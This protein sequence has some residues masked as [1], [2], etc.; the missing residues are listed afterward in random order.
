MSA[1]TETALP[2]DLSAT[3]TK[4]IRGGGLKIASKKSSNG[5]T[6]EKPHFMS[7]IVEL[8]SDDPCFI[9]MHAH[10]NK[11]KEWFLDPQLQ[12]GKL[13]NERRPYQTNRGKVTG[14]EKNFLIKY[15]TLPMEIRSAKEAV[16]W[17]AQ[18]K[19]VPLGPYETFLLGMYEPHNPV[20]DFEENERGVFLRSFT[21]NRKEHHLAIE[22]MDN[23]PF[24]YAEG[25]A[26]I[27]KKEVR[28]RAFCRLR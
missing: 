14:G 3:N 16:S 20:F 4:T 13:L 15:I 9:N 5:T 18:Q 19:V 11:S 10:V 21:L 7:L 6:G 28:T 25:Y 24:L 22:S 26:D 2:I 17:L 12:D 27:W 8:G 23:E 1:N